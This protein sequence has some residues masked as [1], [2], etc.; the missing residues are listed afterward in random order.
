MVAQLA[1]AAA[2]LLAPA[3]AIA[4]PAVDAAAGYSIARTA[5][6]ALPGTDGHDYRVMV[7]WPDTPPPPQGWPVLYVL[8]GED[9]FALV[10][11]TLRRLAKA[12]ARSGIDEGLVVA[13]ESGSL[14]RRVLD[15]T[16]AAEGWA[17]PAG[18]PAAGLATGGADRFL[19]LIERSVAPAV[20]KRWPVDAKRRM[21]LG[22]SFGGLLGLHAF[23]TRPRLFARVA[24]I[25]PS[26]WFGGDLLP[27]EEASHQ[28]GDPSGARLLVAAGGDERGQAGG[29]PATVAG[30]ALVERLN[31]P[32]VPAA[33]RFLALPGQS[34][35]STMLAGLAPAL[36]FAFGREDK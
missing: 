2:L 25:S 33:A 8:D 9:N 10:T 34:H 5:V 27:R 21:L 35:G 20:A 14:A 4:A 17:I 26:L 6:L 18:A 7:S 15:Y 36:G 13:I 19:D 12:G 31:G 24:V 29:A 32:G 16:P 28:A 23:L 3:V 1:I 30:E 11:Q 22:H